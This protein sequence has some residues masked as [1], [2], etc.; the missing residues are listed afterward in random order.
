MWGSDYPHV[1]GTLHHPSGP[2]STRV[3]MQLSFAGVPERW[4]RRMLGGTAIEV[5]GLDA[6]ALAVVAERIAAPGPADLSIPPVPDVV[7]SYWSGA[8]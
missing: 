1:E 3:A 4:T 7:P 2:S 5:F 8:D 6:E